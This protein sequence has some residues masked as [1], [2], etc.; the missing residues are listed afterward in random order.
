MWQLE[1]LT[2]FQ[3]K[4]LNLF[5]WCTF[6]VCIRPFLAHRLNSLHNLQPPA[7]PQLPRS[8]FDGSNVTLQFEHT[9]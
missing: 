7:K 8:A 3:C 4:G 1:S 5:G 6:G 9:N 2:L